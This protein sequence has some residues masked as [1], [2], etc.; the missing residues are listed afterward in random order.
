VKIAEDNPAGWEFAISIACDVVDAV[1][2]V[3]SGANDSSRYAA[4]WVGTSVRMMGEE[5]VPSIVGFGVIKR[6]P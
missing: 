6:A 2:R 1:T 5:V 3:R 4:V